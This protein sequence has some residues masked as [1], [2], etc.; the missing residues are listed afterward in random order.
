MGKNKNAGP[1]VVESPLLSMS[2]KAEKRPSSFP[3]S[4]K[5]YGSSSNRPEEHKKEDEVFVSTKRM[6]EE[7]GLNFIFNVKF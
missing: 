4:P 3:S 2:N 6:I 7:L 1:I 5:K